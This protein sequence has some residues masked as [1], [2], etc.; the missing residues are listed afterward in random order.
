[1]AVNVL[2][3]YLSGRQWSFRYLQCGN[4]VVTSVLRL[5]KWWD[6]CTHSRTCQN[7]T[8]RVICYRWIS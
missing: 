1:V 4:S 2:I 8:R 7:W 3:N 6:Q 5:L